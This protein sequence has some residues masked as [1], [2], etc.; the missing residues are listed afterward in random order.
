MP[1]DHAAGP[2]AQFAKT[3]SVY[4]YLNFKAQ[5]NLL[6]KEDQHHADRDRRAGPAAGEGGGSR[7]DPDDSYT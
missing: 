2:W 4:D 6:E 7:P 1:Q 3:G 5:Q